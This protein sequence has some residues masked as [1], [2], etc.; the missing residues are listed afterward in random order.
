MGKM[1]VVTIDDR[2]RLTVPKEMGLRGSRV[3]I[4]PA[5]SFFVTIPLPGTPLE[6]AGEWLDS[7][8]DTKDLKTLGEDRAKSD[9]VERAKRRKQA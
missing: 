9:A 4:I 5:G 1:A 3:V 8:L 7:E 2:G 6:T